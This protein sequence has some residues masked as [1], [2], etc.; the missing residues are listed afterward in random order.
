MKVG[1]MIGT[2][3]QL[4]LVWDSLGL[5]RN[6]SGSAIMMGNLVGTNV[7]DTT[8]GLMD[9][10]RIVG[11]GVNDV[12]FSDTLEVLQPRCKSQI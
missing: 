3:N 5:S 2:P 9:Y 4:I 12:Y 11:N 8:G 10:S 6:Y 7:S 1:G